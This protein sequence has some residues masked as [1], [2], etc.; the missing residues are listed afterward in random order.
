VTSISNINI[1]G[2]RYQEIPGQFAYTTGVILPVYS[3]FTSSGSPVVPP[4]GTAVIDYYTYD[5]AGSYANGVLSQLNSGGTGE[6]EIAYNRL[7]LY[8]N[9]NLS[10]A[11][12]YW[13][14]LSFSGPITIRGVASQASGPWD[15]RSGQI[16]NG[17]NTGWFVG[18]EVYSPPTTQN[19]TPS[20][21]FGF[22]VQGGT[23]SN[24]TP[25][26]FFGSISVT[27]GQVYQITVGSPSGGPTGSPPNA[28]PAQVNFQF[29]QG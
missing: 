18:V 24:P 9:P 19:G 10:P 8:Y 14:D 17:I 13:Y 2:G 20:S 11:N 25:D 6:R 28:T 23:V 7:E 21:A 26:G 12:R 4:S 3:A 27:P 16:A 29:T 15:N 1:A 22:T 5:Q